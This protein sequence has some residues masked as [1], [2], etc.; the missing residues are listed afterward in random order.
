MRK[1]IIDIAKNV[2]DKDMLEYAEKIDKETENIDDNFLL[3]YSEAILNLLGKFSNGECT[4]CPF[5]Y[6]E[7]VYYCPDFI[8]PEIG[9]KCRLEKC[10]IDEVKKLIRK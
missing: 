3:G 5:S 7:E 6:E 10:W 9:V 8:Y 1:V 2:S 4:D